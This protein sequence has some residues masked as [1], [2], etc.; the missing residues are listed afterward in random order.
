[1]WMMGYND[2]AERELNLPDSFNV[3]RKLRPLVPRPPVTATS[4][5][6]LNSNAPCFTRNIHGTTH[7]LLAF[8]HH[9]ATMAEQSKR[10]FNSTTQQVVVSSR[11]NPTPEQLHTLE[12]LY[13][14]GT[15]TP[16]AEQIQHITAQLRRY[17]KIE[18][19]N[20]FYWFQNHKA[21]ERQ[22]RRRQNETPPSQSQDQQHC[23]DNETKESVT[24]A[25]RTANFEVGWAL[26][27]NCTT[28]LA[29][30]TASIQRGPAAAE[31][32]TDGWLH[33]DEGELFH[34]R[35]HVTWQNKM[36]FSTSSSPTHHLINTCTAAVTT[37]TS[38]IVNST[39]SN[40][41]QTLTTTMDRPKLMIK[42]S[43]DLNY[44]FRENLNC[45]FSNDN[46]DE[47]DCGAPDQTLQL[48][49]LRS[50][51]DHDEREKMSTNFTPQQFFEF[52][53]LK[54]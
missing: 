32:T 14:Q 28:T 21:R 6:T 48:F 29:E 11:W 5:P 41:S 40:V 51:G 47:E 3:G 26:S 38:T 19:K 35:R 2:G 49:P 1:M 46:G 17:G 36:H 52:L 16:S 10:E 33:F 42:A 18:G 53:P 7:D 8:N 30:K 22:K 15:R 34:Q 9:L 31:L 4:I 54:N 37:S 24:E 25:N 20:V 23:P 50:G 39:S 45:S 13:R 44:F 27:R 43:Q 12:E